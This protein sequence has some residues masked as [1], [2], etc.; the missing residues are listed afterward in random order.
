MISG[1]FV[2]FMSIGEALGPVGNSILVQ[3][4]GFRRAYEL[5]SLY[6]L[7]FSICYFCTCGNVAM[8]GAPSC[9]SAGQESNEPE[10]QTELIS[11]GLARRGEV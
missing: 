9:Y 10:E 5:Y 7:F 2:S 4:F 6:I 8:F 3:S 1:L 11:R